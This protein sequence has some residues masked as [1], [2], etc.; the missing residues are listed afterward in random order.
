MSAA[1]QF[2]RAVQFDRYGGGTSAL[3][4]VEIPMPAPKNGQILIKLEAVSINPVDW[5]VQS[6]ELRPILPRKFPHIP[7]SDIAGE[8]V[9]V[10]SGVQRFKVGNKVVATL[11]MSDGGGLAEYAVA[12]ESLT[13]IR[14]LGVSAEEAAALPIAGLTAHHA[15]TKHAG[16]KLDGSGPRK[17]ILVTA[18]SGGVGHYAVQL[19]KLGNTHVTATCGAR[20]IDFVKSLGADEVLDYRTP[21]G[22][23][24]SNS[25]GNK[26]DAVVNGATG[27]SWCTFERVLSKDG[28]VIDLAPTPRGLLTFAVQKIT[29]SKKRLVPFM[30]SAKAENLEYLVGLVKDGKLKSVIDSKYPLSK[31]RDAWSRSIEGHAV[32]KI[33]V[34]P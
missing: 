34:E 14:L 4:H 23:A 21:E 15:L 25:S 11:S 30:L 29:F 10:G 5:K 24:L 1:R 28:V 19:A 16:V 13:A 8:V 3:K 20:N 2:M 26:Y 6:G 22:A 27:I 17:S 7:V 9:E 32:G 18:A 12:K 31:A 33:I